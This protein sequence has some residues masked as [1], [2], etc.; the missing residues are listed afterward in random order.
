M[1][2]ISFYCPQ[3]ATEVTADSKL[4]GD[5]VQCPNCN[6]IL[7]V[8]MPDITEGM[9][10]GD[11]KIIKRLGIGGMGEVWLAEQEAMKRKVALKI[12]APH[13]T[14]DVDFVNRFLQEVQLAGKL[15]HP[16]IV[17]AFHAG[18]DKGIYY[19]AM[20]FIDG[21]ELDSRL[22]IDK[23]IPE[24]E[25]L[26]IIRDIA[27]ALDYAWDKFQILHRDIKPSNIMI[28][29]E[30]DALLMD[31]G[32]SKSL[33][34]DKSLTMSGEIIGTP[35]Y[36]SP[37]QAQSDTSL[38]FRAD[39]YSLGATLF[40]LITGTTPFESDTA[41]GILTQHITSPLPD[42]SKINS[43]LS[44]Q[45]AELIK[46][47]MQKNRENRQG[48]WKE[49]IEDIDLVLNK[50]Y[51]KRSKHSL[52]S[53]TLH[54]LDKAYLSKDAKRINK[55]ALIL[56]LIFIITLLI[57]IKI[58]LLPEIIKKS[59]KSS[60]ID[61]API[62]KSTQSI[63]VAK[64][65]S[66]KPNK[67]VTVTIPDELEDDSASI[68]DDTTNNDDIKSTKQTVQE[69]FWNAAVAFDDS[70]AGQYDL[71]I[72][73]Y[74]SVKEQLA[75]TPFESKAT[76]KL[77]NLYAQKE[78]IIAEVM[79]R[80]ENKA[81]PFVNNSEFRKAAEIYKS[82]NGKFAAET[83]LKRS[84]MA[85]YY[86]EL[87][88]NNNTTS[89]SKD[90]NDEYKTKIMVSV[91]KLIIN[92]E[93]KKAYDVYKNSEISDPNS[94]IIKTLTELTILNKEMFKTLNKYKNNKSKIKLTI[95]NI[96]FSCLIDEITSNFIKVRIVTSKGITWK[97]LMVNNITSADRLRLIKESVST[98]TYIILYG[99][100]FLNQNDIQKAK[101]AF[102]KTGAFTKYFKRIITSPTEAERTFVEL[103]RP[104]DMKAESLVYISNNL[105]EGKYNIQ[106]I[107]SIH[108]KMGYWLDHYS[109]SQFFKENKLAIRLFYESIYAYILI[110]RFP[111][112]GKL[113]EE[114][115]LTAE[116]VNR[117]YDII[118][119]NL[120]IRFKHKKLKE[121]LT[122]TQQQIFEEKFRTL[123]NFFKA[124]PKVRTPKSRITH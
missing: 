101:K 54:K 103:I 59:N 71:V 17:T 76:Q 88:K 41:V 48:S 66:S 63:D 72:S 25:A 94:K 65:E 34:E 6:I 14:K 105:L 56:L 13:L 10:L 19:L 38:D 52:V 79:S 115:K 64:D 100:Y 82:Y 97:K 120:P 40:H 57:S 73:R 117:L 78:A 31:M 58:A 122:E 50:K 43:K 104:F 42:P 49:L 87:D 51:P 53:A 86:L 46:I 121:L 70:H 12:L 35:Y 102:A 84:K 98:T 44:D 106:I 89:K 18:E 113:H 108:E 23:I 114:L 96:R 60:T 75:G 26:K 62:E 36:M 20:E 45:C 67:Q 91:C 16:N 1:S 77:K 107:E 22:K 9:Y 4:A 8:P 33:I 3:C 47:M 2:D 27:I 61:T 85:Y 29:D 112:L 95:N 24:Q 99:C 55:F 110:K 92:K 90:S 15:T 74:E 39:L 21:I 83:E 30:G 69:A 28:S 111:R 116:Q 81:Q 68:E 93:Y 37:E 119:S 32:I 123:G 11:F 109:S 124:V 5:T 80:L 7:L 118:N